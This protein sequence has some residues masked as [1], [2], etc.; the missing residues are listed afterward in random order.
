M[1]TTMRVR[2]NAAIVKKEG[3]LVVLKIFNGYGDP[4]IPFVAD[5]VQIDEKINGTEHTFGEDCFCRPKVDKCVVMH[6]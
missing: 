2:I 6:R 1:D 4:E 3:N 5:S